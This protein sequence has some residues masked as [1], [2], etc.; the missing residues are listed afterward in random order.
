MNAED[1][2]KFFKGDVL[3]DD[4]TLDQY[5]YDASVFKVRPQIVVFPK[6]TE[7]VK[8]LVKFVAQKKS[9]GENIAITPR[10]GGTD[11]SGGAIGESIV[12]VF[13]KYMNRIK[14]MGADFCVVE[15]GLYFRDLEKILDEKNLLLPSYPASKNICAVG[16]MV[17]NNSGG[18]KTLFYGKTEKYVEE[19]KVV[20]SDGEE[21]TIRPLSA[22]E[23]QDKINR[24]DL[25][26]QILRQ[27]Y[28]LATQNDKDIQKAKPNVSKNSAGFPLWN[29]F[30]G[31][32]FHPE[33]IFVGAQGT[34]GL[35]TEIKFRLVPKKKFSRLAAIFIKDMS[36]LPEIIT[37]VLKFRPESLES[38]DDHTMRLAVRFFPAI[39]RSLKIWQSIVLGWLFLPEAW[40]FL[41]G[42]MPKLVML[43][44]ITGD[45]PQEIESRLRGIKDALQPFN[46]EI[47]LAKSEAETQKYWIIRRESFN[48]LRKHVKDKRT[49]PF[50]DDV[51]VR[52]EKLGEFL[53]ELNA[54]LQPYEKDMVYTIAGH[55]GD[56]NFHIIPLMNMRDPR[57]REII[58]EVADKVYDLVLRF[59]GSLT[60]EHN[61]G[62]IRSPYL[63]KMYG[64][65][66]YGLFEEVKKIFD[67]QNIFNPGKK[68]GATKEYYIAHLKTE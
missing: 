52:P 48:L 30:D 9:V 29:V 6:D 34:L 40:M 56:G 57:S 23:T 19:L 8:N 32:T 60:A 42:G 58:P 38:F 47:N 37:A 5:S 7:D 16:G 43:A 49:V 20:L 63:K 21:H 36:R 67:P 46:L 62:L 45:D 53:P 18:E 51:I 55:P 13:T 68:I 15:P 54:I 44:E 27:L 1:I 61:D 59:G 22:E 24:N 2:K 35:I 17:S 26:S 25:E 39:A 28:Q 14:E 12:V 11:M 33:Q 4:A 41:T 64:E 3:A 10:A 66:I 31:K 65:K 50:I